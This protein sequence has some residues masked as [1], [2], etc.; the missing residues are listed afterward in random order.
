[1]LIH[2]SHWERRQVNPILE[3]ACGLSTEP[4][5][6]PATHI[7]V[8]CKPMSMNVSLQVSKNVKITWGESWAVEGMLKHFPTKPL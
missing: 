1:M 7:F 4:H 5:L 2:L 3:N 8:H 6:Y